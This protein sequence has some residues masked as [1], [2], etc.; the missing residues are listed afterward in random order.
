LESVS[1][2]KGTDHLLIKKQSTSGLSPG[3]TPAKVGDITPGEAE[4]SP[5]KLA[6][7]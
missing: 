5:G 3:Y 4:Y 1:P 2:E 6:S 7:T